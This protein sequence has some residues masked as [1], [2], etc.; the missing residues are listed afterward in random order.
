MFVPKTSEQSANAPTQ[1]KKRI[2][3]KQKGNSYER[4]M[5]KT[6]REI[7][8]FLF[9]KTSRQASR[10]LDDCG[11]DLSGIP[12]N[13]S[14]KCGYKKARPKPEELLK[15][16]T[17]RLAENFPKE[18]PIHKQLTFI[19]HKLDGHHPAHHLVYMTF[20]TWCELMEG[21]LGFKNAGRNE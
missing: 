3:S 6:F 2:N 12:I 5:A 1:G 8:G 18:D 11:I 9:C 14:L 13:V 7:F 19:I 21:Y 4:L 20:D 10:L 16:I 17:Q 15:N